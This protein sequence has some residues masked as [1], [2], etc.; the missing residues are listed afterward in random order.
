LNEFIPIANKELQG[1]WGKISKRQAHRRFR[2]DTT[3]AP[4]SQEEWGEEP[5]ALPPPGTL[6]FH[7]QEG[8]PPAAVAGG[9][10][11]NLEPLPH[12]IGLL[13]ADLRIVAMDGERSVQISGIPVSIIQELPF[14]LSH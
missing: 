1:K 7:S 10:D 8:F 6:Q 11:Q 5:L 9:G 2:R 3:Y 4:E 12:T 13:G 14:W